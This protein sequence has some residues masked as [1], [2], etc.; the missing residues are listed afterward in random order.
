MKADQD[1][2]GEMTAYYIFQDECQDNGHVWPSILS[3]LRVQASIPLGVM[4]KQKKH[5]C[6]SL[7]DTI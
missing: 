6:W 4:S 3:S 5:W 2:G 1:V 7:Y